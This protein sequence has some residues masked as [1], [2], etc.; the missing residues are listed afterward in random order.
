MKTIHNKNKKG[1]IFGS[2]AAACYGTNPL[3]TLPMYSAGIGANSVLFYRYA[4]ALFIYAL[5]IKFVTKKSFAI[6]KNAI[7]PLFIMG[8]LFS[9]SSLLL[10][11]AFNFID[12]GIAC[13]ILFSYPIFVAIIMGIFFKEKITKTVIFSLTLCIIGI[14]LLHKGDTSVALN[15]KGILLVLLSSL[16]YAIYIVGV[17]N[18]PSIK[19]LK[20]DILTFY[21]ML[22]GLLVYIFNLK[23]CTE[24]QIL[25]T[26][27]LWILAICL[28]IIPTILSLETLGIAIKL[29]GSTKTAILGSFEPLTALF[30]GVVVFHEQITLKIISGVILIIFGVLLIILKKNQQ[31]TN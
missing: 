4:L 5:W 23:F 21:V 25:N 6:H 15:F 26:P 7:L 9:V 11:V 14:S 19:H 2:I 20:A 27:F 22:F 17:K 12:A 30:F 16:S 29:I 24:L 1:L 31:T 3:F 10:F 13:T 18:I 8:T 28:A